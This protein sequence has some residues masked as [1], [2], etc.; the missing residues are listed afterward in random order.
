MKILFSDCYRKNAIVQRIKF[1]SFCVC[2]YFFIVIFFSVYQNSEWTLIST[3]PSNRRCTWIILSSVCKCGIVK[4]RKFITVRHFGIICQTQ[5]QPCSLQLFAHSLAPLV[6][7][8]TAVFCQNYH[9]LSIDAENDHTFIIISTF[10]LPK[11]SL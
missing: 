11:T 3:V 5:F 10:Q 7:L 4:K 8:L 6:R 9:G 1:I 2:V